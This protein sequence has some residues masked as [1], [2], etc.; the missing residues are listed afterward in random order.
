MKLTKEQETRRK[1]Y[2]EIVEALAVSQE[3][4]AQAV[5]V[6]RECIS[7]RCHGHQ[8]ITMEALFALRH[9]RDNPEILA[10]AAPAKAK[11]PDPMDELF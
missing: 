1:Q 9:V 3:S 6:R 4:I 2:A 11:K 5:D 7:K 10:G 8:P